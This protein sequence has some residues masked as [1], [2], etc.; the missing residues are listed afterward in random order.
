M[1][2]GGT[3]GRQDQGMKGGSMAD[4]MPMMMSKMNKEMMG[5]MNKDMEA[6]TN[7]MMQMTLMMQMN[8]MV[9][10]MHQMTSDC[11]RMMEHTGKAPGMTAKPSNPAPQGE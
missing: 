8:L 11:D 4:M 1:M 10:E 3:V 9:A 6:Q 2:G 7:M 5:V